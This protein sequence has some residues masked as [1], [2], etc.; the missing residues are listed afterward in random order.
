LNRKQTDKHG[1][2]R[3]SSGEHLE[4]GRRREMARSGV[5][6]GA[7]ASEVEKQGRRTRGTFCKN[8]AG[9]R[10][11]LVVD[12]ARSPK[13]RS[14]GGE[15]GNRVARKGV[16]RGGI[17]AGRPRTFLQP[18]KPR[19]FARGKHKPATEEQ[20]KF[21]RSGLQFNDGRNFLRSRRFVGRRVLWRTPWKQPVAGSGT[22]VPLVPAGRFEARRTGGN[23]GWGSCAR[24]RSRVRSGP[25]VGGGLAARPAGVKKKPAGLFLRLCSSPKGDSNPPAVFTRETRWGGRRRK[26][27]DKPEGGFAA[28]GTTGRDFPAV[29]SGRRVY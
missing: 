28:Q 1:G 17:R 6:V 8:A 18:K 11:N 16:P 21:G 4:A 7:P 5:H 20:S 24:A 25:E 15:E 22:L 13:P 3:K 26:G 29:A 14:A 10:P 19:T 9:P 2:P 27:G 23:P 12:G